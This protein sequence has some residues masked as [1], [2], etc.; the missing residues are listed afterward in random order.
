VKYIGSL[1]PKK[2]DDL[3]DYLQRKRDYKIFNGIKKD[4]LTKDDYF[5]FDL[6]DSLFIIGL[7]D[8]L[9]SYRK[10]KN[11]TEMDQQFDMILGS[12]SNME[13]NNR[14]LPYAMLKQ[15]VYNLHRDNSYMY[16]ILIENA[17][18]VRYQVAGSKSIKLPLKPNKQLE[19]ILQFTQPVINYVLVSKIDKHNKEIFEEIFDL[20]I[21]DNHANSRLLVHFLLTF[22]EFVENAPVLTIKEFYNLK[23]KW[24]EEIFS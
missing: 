4:V 7:G 3:L 15:I 22:Y 19:K 5:N 23:K 20:Q 8:F 1:N 24:R 11:Y 21:T 18:L 12:Y 16:N 10:E 14:G 6:F 17:D 13:R 2:S 9:K